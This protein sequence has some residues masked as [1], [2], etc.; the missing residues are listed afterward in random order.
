[1]LLLLVL[2]KFPS[3]S[4]RS[5]FQEAISFP[6]CDSGPSYDCVEICKKKS[7]SSFRLSFANVVRNSNAACL[8][9]AN[10]IPIGSSQFLVNNPKQ[11]FSSSSLART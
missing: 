6:K 9:G 2:L 5:G 11:G 7:S 10:A 3:S 1:M 4:A 8:I